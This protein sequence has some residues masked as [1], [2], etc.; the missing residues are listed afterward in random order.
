[1]G[2]SGILMIEQ[3]IIGIDIIEIKRIRAAV[4]RWQDRFLGRIF[5][6]KELELYRD[7]VESLAAR[8][9]GKEAAIK[10]LNPQDA[11]ISWRN[12]EI[13]SASS[14]KPIISLHGKALEQIQK[15]GFSGLEIS[16]AHSREN[17][18]ALVIGLRER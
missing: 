3:V 16:L 1:M 6:L 2:Y 7:K 17:A 18:I 12:I 4:E 5:T 9:A 15:L 13:L 14:G 11:T 8:F 10:A